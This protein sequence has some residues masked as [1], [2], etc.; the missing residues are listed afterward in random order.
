MASAKKKKKNHLQEIALLRRKL[1]SV[2]SRSELQQYQKRFIELSSQ[3]SL[4]LG[5]TR[6][7]YAL[8]NSLSD[9]FTYLTKE[10]EFLGN[11]KENFP[12]A[13]NGGKDK[14][15]RMVEF[16][17]KWKGTLVES[18]KKVREREE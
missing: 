9:G 16:M 5:E 11:V 2:P 12:M 8:Y 18:L 13:V 15:G 1:D 7:C 14:Q 6:R 4:R 10:I 3:V 17:E